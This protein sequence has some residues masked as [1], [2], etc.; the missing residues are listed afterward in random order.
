[1]LE[2]VCT[3]LTAVIMLQLFTVATALLLEVH[4]MFRLVAK[5]LSVC[6]P[7]KAIVAEIGKT[8]NPVKVAVFFVNRIL[9]DNYIKFNKQKRLTFSDSLFIQN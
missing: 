4:V 5:V 6:V 2:P 7:P 8:E 1:M 3:M 9:N